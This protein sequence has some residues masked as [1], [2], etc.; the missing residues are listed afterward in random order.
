MIDKLSQTKQQIADTID[1][2]QE[3]KD[4]LDRMQIKSW[5]Y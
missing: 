4:A 5:R 2:L 3:A 1:K